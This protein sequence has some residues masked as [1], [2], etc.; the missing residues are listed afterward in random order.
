VTMSQPGRSVSSNA[1]SLKILLYLRVLHC[2][3][4]NKN[5]LNFRA[6]KNI[7]QSASCKIPKGLNLDVRY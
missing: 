5:A 3:T 6:S 1:K 2:F 4:V 7:Y